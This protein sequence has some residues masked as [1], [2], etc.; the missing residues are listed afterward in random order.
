LILNEIVRAHNLQAKPEQVRALVAESAQ[1]YEQPE[2]VIRWHY[3]KPE[4]LNEF[5]FAAVERNVI[6]WTLARA[7]V[8]DQATSFAALMD[9]VGA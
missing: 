2:A 8:T 7:Q 5:E 9:P 3:E 6:D 4:R 1:S